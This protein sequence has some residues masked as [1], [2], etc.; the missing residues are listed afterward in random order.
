MSSVFAQIGLRGKAIARVFANAQLSYPLGEAIAKAHRVIA[1]YRTVACMHR[2]VLLTCHAVACMHRAVISSRRP[3]DYRSPF[4]IATA[5]S[6]VRSPTLATANSISL[7]SCVF[8]AVFE[9]D[10]YF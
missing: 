6:R 8:S 10:R 4:A 3:R 5:N 2:R 7:S 9:W 1:T